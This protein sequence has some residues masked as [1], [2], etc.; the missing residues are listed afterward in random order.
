MNSESIMSKY[1][2]VMQSN[3]TP[4]EQMNLVIVKLE[5]VPKNILYIPNHV[6]YAILQQLMSII[7]V[8]YCIIAPGLWGTFLLVDKGFY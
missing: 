6:L 1:A 8:N 3:E 4:A 5:I 2:F 7:W